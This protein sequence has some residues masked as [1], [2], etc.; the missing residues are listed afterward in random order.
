MTPQVFFELAVVQ[1]VSLADHPSMQSFS[2]LDPPVKL[3]TVVKDDP[4]ATD[5]ADKLFLSCV[6]LHVVIQ[7]TLVIAAFTTSMAEEDL[8]SDQK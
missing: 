7:S 4:S 1:K 5:I 2:C 3:R 6:G 8:L